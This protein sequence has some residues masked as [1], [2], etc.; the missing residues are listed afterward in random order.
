M[1]EVFLRRALT[2]AEQAIGLSS[3]NPRV[4]CV[5]VKEGQ[6]IGEGHT[7]AAGSAHAEVMAIGDATA[8]GHDTADCTVYVT[9][10]P[11]SHFGRT[12]PCVDALKS[13]QPARVVVALLDVNPQVSGQGVSVL[14]SAGML[15]DVL[16]SSH[17]IAV[18]AHELNIGFIERMT[19]GKVYTRLKTAASLDGKTALPDGRSQ[20]ITS[21]AARADGHTWRAR[22]DVIVTGIGTVLHDNP[23]MNVRGARIAHPPMKCVVD[24]YART[25][26]NARLFEDDT[27]VC[28]VCADLDESHDEYAGQSARLAALCAAH[29]AVRIVRLPMLNG[30]V[31]LAALWVYFHEQSF[32]EIHVEAGGVLN[33]ALLS[34]GL[35]DELL[36]YQAPRVVG[37]GLPMADFSDALILDDLQKKPNW[38]WLDVV[39]LGED[40]RLRLRKT[41]HHDET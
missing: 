17:P 36:I 15:V 32:N 28:V 10:E 13:I 27:S 37:A 33:A 5:L 11:C 6:I 20:W 24:S 34:A 3:P 8:R 22:A 12:P 7:Q 41:Q 35:I 38:Q 25:P 40:V 1:D 31:D 30:R 18:A 19:R 2:L 14:R 16:P 26:L 9:L 39:R 21:D 23:Q 29:T 4:G